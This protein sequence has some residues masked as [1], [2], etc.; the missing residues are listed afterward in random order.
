[1]YNVTSQFEYKEVKTF[2]SQM[3]FY[4]KN[5]YLKL[6]IDDFDYNYLYKKCLQIHK[7]FFFLK[8]NIWIEPKLDSDCDPASDD[9]L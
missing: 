2:S 5:F 3:G 1:M 7:A 4:L 6:W 9:T 8:Y